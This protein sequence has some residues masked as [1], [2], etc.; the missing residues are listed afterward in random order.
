[1]NFWN[2]A[3]EV[4]ERRDRW[5]AADGWLSRKVQY[6]EIHNSRDL[7]E[8]VLWGL[9]LRSLAGYDKETWV[10]YLAGLLSDE[11]LG[12]RHTNAISLYLNVR[13]QRELGLQP[14]GP[15]AGLD[16]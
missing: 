7:L 4:A 11:W 12:E 14:T 10:W 6:S 1:M 8:K 2:M 9:R 15:A 16:L 5:R 3:V 13:A